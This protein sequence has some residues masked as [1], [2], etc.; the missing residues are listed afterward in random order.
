MTHTYFH[1]DGFEVQA[2]ADDEARWQSIQG[3][4]P[5]VET[6]V[7]SYGRAAIRWSL[8]AGAGS[9]RIWSERDAEGQWVNDATPEEGIWM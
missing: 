4:A 6:T 3:T 9:L 7:V 8:A 5:S 1:F 2:D